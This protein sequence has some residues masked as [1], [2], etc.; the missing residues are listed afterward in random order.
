MC[1]DWHGQDPVAKTLKR[2]MDLNA[3]IPLLTL[4][5]ILHLTGKL[6]ACEFLA[7]GGSIISNRNQK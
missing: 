3:T 4:R 5:L 7:Y 1:C 6:T 2:G